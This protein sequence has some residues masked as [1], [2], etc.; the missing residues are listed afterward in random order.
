MEIRKDLKDIENEL[1]RAVLIA[2][3][4]REYDADWVHNKNQE[5]MEEIYKLPHHLYSQL[6]EVYAEGRQ[7]ARSLT[8]VLYSFNNVEV[9]SSIYSWVKNLENNWIKNSIYYKDLIV[10]AEQ[11]QDNIERKYNS[12]NQMIF[13][14]NNQI[15]LLEQIS[16]LLIM[17]KC[18]S[19]YLTEERAI[20]NSNKSTFKISDNID[21]YDVFISHASEDKTQYV[22]PLC[23]KFESEGIKIWYDKNEILWGDNIVKK[24]NHG[25]SKSKYVIVVLSI[26][27]IRKNWTNAELEAVLNIETNNGDIRILPLLIGDENEIKLILDEYPLIAGKLHLKYLDGTEKITDSLKKRLNAHQKS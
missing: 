22:E 24:I 25:L 6:E 11:I 12:I 26:N 18:K 27:F 2:E 8:Y 1:N 13:T 3:K 21:Y 23:K 15:K 14:L 9:H 17:I 4:L 10:K 20:N 16:T 7:M 5:D 19:I